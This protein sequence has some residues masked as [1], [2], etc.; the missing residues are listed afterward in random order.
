MNIATLQEI[1]I[2]IQQFVWDLAPKEVATTYAVINELTYCLGRNT[3]VITRDTEGKLQFDTK[4][5]GRLFRP[6]QTVH[7]PVTY[8]SEYL[9]KW[10]G[11]MVYYGRDAVR[12]VRDS[13]CRLGCFTLEDRDWSNPFNRSRNPNPCGNVSALR[14]LLTAYAC[15]ERLLHEGIEVDA[16][17]LVD[18]PNTAGDVTPVYVRDD[19]RSLP[20]HKACT[21][22]VLFNAA[23]KGL[24]RWHRVDME[25]CFGRV[26]EP[27]GGWGTPHPEVLEAIS[28]EDLSD[29]SGVLVGDRPD[30]VEPQPVHAE[31]TR[32]R[33]E[34]WLEKGFGFLEDL[35]NLWAI[36]CVDILPC[37]KTRGF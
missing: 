8:I 5:I 7:S 37:P 17:K 9:K 11:E 33:L 2:E 18:S 1:Y 31:G 3:G 12:R 22:V 16:Q 23:F 4:N 32:I 13:L 21:L 27:V 30:F 14:L 6:Q 36:E 35:E 24:M 26:E 15:E 28:A 34:Q 20:Q 29:V 10:W 19:A 25:D